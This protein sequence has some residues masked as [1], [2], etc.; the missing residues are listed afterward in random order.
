MWAT[1]RRCPS[2]PQPWRRRSPRAR[3]PSAYGLPAPGAAVARCTTRFSNAHRTVCRELLYRLHPWFECDVFVHSAI[4]KADGGVFR[5]TL[6]GSEAGRWLEI[7]A[8]M[9]DRAACVTDVRSLTDPFVSLEA[10]GALSALLDQ[11]LKTDAPSSNARLRDAYGISRDQNRGETHGRE[12]ESQRS[13]FGANGAS[14]HS[15]WICSQAGSCP[16]RRIGP[17]CRGTHRRRCSG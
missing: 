17:T 1:R 5:C 9:F 4:D 10:L 12:D 14:C 11:V 7:P 16:A 3:P 2:C 8:W 13:G 6:D 15:R